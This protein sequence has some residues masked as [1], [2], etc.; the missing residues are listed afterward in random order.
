MAKLKSI[1][2][3][4]GQLDGFSFYKLSGQIIVRKTGGFDGKKIKEQ[5]NYRRTRENASEFGHC[6][7][8]G[9]SFRISL[10]P[11]L[12]LIGNP[13]T[14]GLVAQL[15]TQIK[16]LDNVSERGKRTVSEGLKTSDGK[17]I[18]QCFFLSNRLSLEQ[19]ITQIK[20]DLSDCRF[21]FQFIA[22]HL[23]SDIII[24]VKVLLLSFDFETLKFQRFESDLFSFT[25]ADR[26]C[27][28]EGTL[29][30]STETG[31][32]L[33]LLYVEKQQPI[34]GENYRLKENGIFIVGVA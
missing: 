31:T 15:F 8:T 30:Y 10:Q 24:T 32:V 1:L 9:K 17:K 20:I 22:D 18:L 26:D 21:S 16:N 27:S 34:N 23:S 5:S 25:T 4:E 3:I 14:H 2:Q 19:Y 13:Q 6:S 29:P 7:K 12:K 28:I 33:G 11:Y